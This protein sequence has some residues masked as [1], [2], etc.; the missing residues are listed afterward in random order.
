LCRDCV[1]RAPSSARGGSRS[2]LAACARMQTLGA[3]H[4]IEK[5]SRARTF[6]MLIGII[7]LVLALLWKRLL[8]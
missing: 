6:G 2:R 8:R 7:I 3:K 5:A 4:M 1:G